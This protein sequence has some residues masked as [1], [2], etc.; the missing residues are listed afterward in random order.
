M[1]VVTFGT[2]KST[3]KQVLI[4]WVTMVLVYALSNF[5]LIVSVVGAANGFTSHKTEY[6]ATPISFARAFLSLFFRGYGHA[7]SCHLLMIPWI[8]MVFIWSWSGKYCGKL[9]FREIQLLKEMTWLLVV[10]ISIALFYAIWHCSPIVWARN[11][12]RGVFVEFQVDR[13]YWLYPLIWFLLFAYSL[14][15]AGVNF[16]LVEKTKIGKMIVNTA[17][18]C[19]GTAISVYQKYGLCKCKGLVFGGRTYRRIRF[20]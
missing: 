8:L 19:I 20:N 2:K 11:Q 10:A 4:G 1:L 5:Q 18:I 17:I 3:V 14:H 12:M 9:K 6:V 15:L 16:A 7:D 13:F